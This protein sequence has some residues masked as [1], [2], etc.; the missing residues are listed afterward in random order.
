MEEERVLIL[1]LDWIGLDGMQTDVVV[2]KIDESSLR[3]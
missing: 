2:V 3:F 1:T